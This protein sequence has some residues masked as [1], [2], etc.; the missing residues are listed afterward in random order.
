MS[1]WICKSSFGFSQ[2]GTKARR[3]WKEERFSSTNRDLLL[4][5]EIIMEEFEEGS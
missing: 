2:L 3:L 5:M 1:T 4:E